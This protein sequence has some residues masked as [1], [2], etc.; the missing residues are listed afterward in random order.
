MVCLEDEVATLEQVLES[1]NTKIKVTTDTV[2]GSVSLEDRCS[3]VLQEVEFLAVRDCLLTK[4]CFPGVDSEHSTCLSEKLWIGF[5]VD[6]Y[7]VNVDLAYFV[8]KAVQLIG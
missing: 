2:V 6:E 8:D 5:A 7:I 1:L 4:F 3:G